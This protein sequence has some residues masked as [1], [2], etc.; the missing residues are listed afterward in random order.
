MIFDNIPPSVS[1]PIKDI[2]FAETK[3]ILWN[4]GECI[5]E[6]VGNFG[7]HKFGKIQ[8]PHLKCFVAKH[9][10][11]HFYSF[12]NQI[13]DLSFCS[14]FLLFFFF[15]FLFQVDLQSSSDLIRYIL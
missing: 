13:S 11:F 4:V 8:D 2:P 1:V 9:T 10:S 3:K 15:S 14:F 7:S 6:H 5:F 12:V